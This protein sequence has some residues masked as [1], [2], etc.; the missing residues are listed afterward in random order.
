MKQFSIV[1]KHFSK[2]SDLGIH[3]SAE[4]DFA[5]PFFVDGN[6]KQKFEESKLA[7]LSEIH[8]LRGT[9]VAYND[10]PPATNTTIF[11]KSARQI[12]EDLR[13]HFQFD[14]T[15]KLIVDIS[16]Y[17]RQENGD[18]VSYR[19]L[20]AGTEILPESSVIKFDCCSDLINL[21]KRDK[22]E[23]RQQAIQKFKDLIS[24]IDEKE[25]NPDFKENLLEY[26]K[27]IKTIE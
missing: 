21:L 11:K 25:I 24:R 6:D 2:E 15:E 16:A 3:L 26:K 5:L 14:T 10:N 7:E 18:I 1:W 20:L 27:W 4:E 13:I 12:I 8:L 19:A 17:M 22:L 23:D 9:L